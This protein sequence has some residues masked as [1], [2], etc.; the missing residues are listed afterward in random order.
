MTICFG[1]CPL[2]FPI[3]DAI[4]GGCAPFPFDVLGKMY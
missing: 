2:D 4:L 3:S 1:M